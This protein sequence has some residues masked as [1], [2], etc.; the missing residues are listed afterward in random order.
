MDFSPFL[1]TSCFS[2]PFEVAPQHISQLKAQNFTA[3]IPIKS[4]KNI[5]WNI[6]LDQRGKKKQTNNTQKPDQG[7]R[8][9]NPNPKNPKQLLAI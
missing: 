9:T 6:G 4:Y 3:G 8:K 2:D 7:K 1:P 5:I